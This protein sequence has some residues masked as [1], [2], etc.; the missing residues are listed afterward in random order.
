M[1]FKI[2]DLHTDMKILLQCKKDSEEFINN[3][4]ENGFKDYPYYH[5]IEE[6]LLNN[7]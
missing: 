5:I 3:N 7:D 2:A 6:K 4:I 1:V